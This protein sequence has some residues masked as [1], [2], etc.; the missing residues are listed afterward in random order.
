MIKTFGEKIPN[1]PWEKKPAD[2]PGPVWRYS[3]NPVIGRNPIPNVTR[4]FNS[5]VATWKGGEA[6]VENRSGN[7]VGVFR[8]ET[9]NGIPYLYFGFSD[10]AL[11]WKFSE[12]KMNI[13][14][15]DGRDANPNYAYD[16]RLIKIGDTY[17]IVWCTDFHGASIGIATTRDFRT[18][19]TR[20]NGFLPFN[21][22]GVLFPRKVDGK[23]LML[24]RPSDSG[25]TPFGDIF[26]SE[27][28]DLL[29][30]GNHKWVMG[31]SG[32]WWQSVKIGAGCAPIETEEGW[33]LIYHGVT[34]TCSGFLYSMGAAILDRD[35]PWRV[36][37]RCGNFLL[38]PEAEYEERGFV[39]SVVFPCA[40]LVDSETNRMAIYYG[41]ADTNTALAFTTVD[42]V[43]EYVKKFDI[44]K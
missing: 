44:I 29:H 39:P 41:A 4:I 33:L 32:E 16:P 8:A 24:T 5:A 36:S 9:C 13:T 20:G 21:R 7:F 2:C 40:A 12:G 26:I 22:N 42:D 6:S 28:D 10:D 38:T 31:K 15:E 25:H 37:H 43:V 19:T 11:N 1:I 35:E 14:D 3:K 27:S 18:F 17:H 34:G 30:W 23:Y